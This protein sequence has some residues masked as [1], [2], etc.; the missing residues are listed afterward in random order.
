MPPRPFSQFLSS[1]WQITK[2]HFTSLYTQLGCQLTR[3]TVLICNQRPIISPTIPTILVLL[4]FFLSF[5]LFL[6]TPTQS[7][8]FFLCSDSR[9][10]RLNGSVHGIAPSSWQGRRN[11]KTRH[12]VQQRVTHTHTQNVVSTPLETS[13]SS[14]VSDRYASLVIIIFP[15]FSDFRK[16]REREKR[17]WEREIA[18]Q[19]PP[20]YWSHEWNTDFLLRDDTYTHGSFFFFLKTTWER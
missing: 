13:V 14:A 17:E 12:A 4:F 18:T 15:F 10:R 7:L 20:S 6:P 19:R 3:D 5:S 8:L 9:S 1:E 16:D 11:S 2:T